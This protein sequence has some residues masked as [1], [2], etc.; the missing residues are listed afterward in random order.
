[1]Q[2]FFTLLGYIHTTVTSIQNK[3][4]LKILIFN[5]MKILKIISED[6][7]NIVMRYS[8]RNHALQLKNTTLIDMV[9]ELKVFILIHPQ[10]V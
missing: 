8:A 9:L 2:L 10:S 1:M 6:I 5:A 3:G 4:C 7:E